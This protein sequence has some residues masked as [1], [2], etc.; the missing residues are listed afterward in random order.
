MTVDTGGAT[1]TMTTASAAG[2]QASEVR[3]PFPGTSATRSSPRASGL[4]PMCLGTTGTQPRCM[5]RGPPACVPRRG[6]DRRPVHHQELAALPRRLLTVNFR[7]PSYEF[8]FNVGVY[9]LF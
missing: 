2:H 3:G 7:Q 5:A 9:L 8:T 1:T 4:R 6:S